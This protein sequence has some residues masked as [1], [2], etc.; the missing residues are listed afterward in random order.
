MSGQ[1]ICELVPGPDASG[2]ETIGAIVIEPGAK[3]GG[4][5]GESGKPQTADPGAMREERKVVTALFADLA[6]STSLAERLDPEE[7]KLIVSEA[8]ARL[9]L[10]VEEMGGTIKDLAGDGV[11]ALFGAPVSHEDDP[12]RAVRTALRMQEDL[13]AYAADVARAWGVEGF[14]VRIGVHTGPVVLGPTG[15]GSRVE[16]AAFGDTVN[17]AARLQSAARPAAVLV[18]GETRELVE[19]HFRWGEPQLL[20]LK[21]K[22]GTQAACEVTGLAAVTVRGRAF[23]LRAAL[24]GRDRELAQAEEAVQ[25]GRAS[26]R[27]RV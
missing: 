13:S 8:V 6:G 7:V 3:E 21:G 11:L 10:A 14:G 27:E 23:G 15:S 17:T 12:E 2:Q 18:S 16:Y 19:P 9:V 1:G 4:P 5:S 26:C 20:E 22:S 24:V 25:I